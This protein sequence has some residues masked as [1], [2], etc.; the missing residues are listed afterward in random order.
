MPIDNCLH[1]FEYLASAI[2]PVYMS[3]PPDIPKDREVL[4]SKE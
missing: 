1:S 2:L 4:F 3:N